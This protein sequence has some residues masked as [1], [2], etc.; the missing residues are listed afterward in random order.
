M[1]IRTRI[2]LVAAVV[3]YGVAVVGVASTLY[4]RY[5]AD[6]SFPVIEQMSAVSD[7]HGHLGLKIVGAGLDEDL[8]LVLMPDTIDSPLLVAQ[9]LDKS[10]MHDVEVYGDYLL[11]AMGS[12]GVGVLSCRA[13]GRQLS[14]VSQSNLGG[15]VADVEVVGSHLYV[16]LSK[17]ARL[18]KLSLL[19]LP[20]APDPVD[21]FDLPG[22]PVAM[23][24]TDD[25]IYIADPQRGLWS[26]SSDLKSSASPEDFGISSC[27]GI[28]SN[29]RDLFTIDKSGNL[30]RISLDGVQKPRLE[31]QFANKLRG[32]A[33]D[34]RAVYV[35]SDDGHLYVFDSQEV[36]RS[37]IIQEV[38]NSRMYS[39]G[40]ELIQGGAVL[41][42]ISPSQGAVLYQR[43][44]DGR[45]TPAGNILLPG[46]FSSVVEVDRV[47]Y[48]ATSRGVS[49]WSLAGLPIDSERSFYHI[50]DGS[51]RNIDISGNHLFAL[52]RKGLRVANLDRMDDAPLVIPEVGLGLDMAR[53]RDHLWI[54]REE[55]PVG[56][57]HVG[58]DG[59]LTPCGDVE[60]TFD[61][62]RVAAAD[63]LLAIGDEHVLRV[64]A[65]SD[66]C[67]PSLLDQFPLKNKLSDV[68]VS[69]RV[70]YAVSPAAGEVMAFRLGQAGGKQPV[71]HYRLPRPLDAFCQPRAL[72]KI[73]DTLYVS[74]G[75]AGLLALNVSNPEALRQLFY[76]D[77]PSFAGGLR[78]HDGILYVADRDQGVWLLDHAASKESG[79]PRIIGS[80]DTV[81]DVQ[82]LAF[83]RGR[84]FLSGSP[85]G[86]VVMDEP[87][88]LEPEFRWGGEVFLPFSKDFKAGRYRVQAYSQA[89]HIYQNLLVEVPRF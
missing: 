16:L 59:T 19:T 65:I 41:V 29:S 51:V 54:A 7:E 71:G 15:R 6:N 32:V 40:L 25:A 28:A 44:K 18:L 53:Q 49:A 67:Q 23:H 84:M 87:V 36:Q 14:L 8:R 43:D 88:V 10:Y 61:G 5:Q 55:A 75:R 47:L 37:V 9:S 24:A 11:V 76:V 50:V 2:Y 27:L 70:I 39:S 89:G 85:K 45:L 4:A 74:L 68:L 77:T 3:V 79:V 66:P 46:I 42:D 86:I 78:E 1:R 33:A 56:G 31:H 34:D 22:T 21:S 69:G 81:V 48:V 38:V 82:D 62:S 72:L 57:F 73:D 17:P 13:P 63:G 52:S 60:D 58:P 80:F 12:K 20:S 64:Y 35:Q 30:W 83:D 26:I